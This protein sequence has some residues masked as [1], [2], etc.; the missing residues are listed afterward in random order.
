MTPANVE[1][2]FEDVVALLDRSIER[3]E[4]YIC[5]LD[6]ELSDFVRMNRGKVRQPGT[7]SQCYL[8]LRIITGQRH[9][10]HCLSLAGD[11]T[12]DRAA[13]EAALSV[14]RTTVSAL[15]D[16]PHL[17]YAMEVR[18]SRAVRSRSRCSS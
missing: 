9:A 7:V 13:I 10:E 3:D 5:R 18:P 4:I 8:R 14:L 1:T 16:D 6:A 11:L 2:Y 17:S 12:R 15:P